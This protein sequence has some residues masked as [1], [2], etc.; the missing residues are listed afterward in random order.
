MTIGVEANPKNAQG[1]LTPAAYQS[2]V[3]LTAS[4]V[5]E[6]RLDRGNPLHGIKEILSGN[7]LLRH[8]DITGK[9]CPKLFTD[10]NKWA[11]FRREVAVEYAKDWLK[12]LFSPRK[13]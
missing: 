10:D 4:L 9:E 13:E 8:A 5:R 1:E 2:M 6:T 12:A 7:A 11:Q 3:E